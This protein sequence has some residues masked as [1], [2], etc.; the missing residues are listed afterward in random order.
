M[1]KKTYRKPCELPH[2]YRML[3]WAMEFDPTMFYKINVYLIEYLITGSEEESE[4]ITHVATYTVWSAMSKKI[5]SKNSISP[6]SKADANLLEQPASIRSIAVGH[7]Y[8][9]FDF[10]IQRE[11]T[12]REE[13][14]IWR[15]EVWLGIGHSLWRIVLLL[16]HVAP[17]V[18]WRFGW[19]GRVSSSCFFFRFP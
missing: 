12:L 4:L 1:E 3:S 18:G 17:E 6:V 15:L 13:L 11:K 7:I 9:G 5:S 16:R 19:H 2:M 8:R 10:F 14:P